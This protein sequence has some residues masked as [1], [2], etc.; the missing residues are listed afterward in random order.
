MNTYKITNVTHELHKRDRKYLADVNFQY[1][2]K[3]TKKNINIKTGGYVVLTV[4]VLP[5]PV[6]RLRLKKL[7][8]VEE[9]NEP[10]P[11][12]EK[13]PEVVEEKPIKSALNKK[14]MTVDVPNTNVD[15]KK[16]SVKKTVKD[17]EE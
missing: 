2:D 16:K 1:V 5:L 10:K 4:P 15:N 12:V 3:L 14:K 11:V 13:T 17:K 7:V 6:H 8:I 9:V